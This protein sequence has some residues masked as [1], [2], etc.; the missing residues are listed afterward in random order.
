M[1]ATLT[2]SSQILIFQT[3]GSSVSSIPNL[4]CNRNSTVVYRLFA[5]KGRPSPP[6][7]P[8]RTSSPSSFSCVATHSAMTGTPKDSSN[9]VCYAFIEPAYVNVRVSRRN[10]QGKSYDTARDWLCDLN[11]RLDRDIGITK[12]E[13]VGDDCVCW[14]RCFGASGSVESN[15]L[16]WVWVFVHTPISSICSLCFNT[17]T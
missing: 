14:S 11:D 4:V 6:C 5:R 1:I 12:L 16:V 15:F 2:N 8:H 3:I 10:V 7:S 9:S 13:A 17:P